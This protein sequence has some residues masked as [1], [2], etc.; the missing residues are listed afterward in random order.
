MPKAFW[1]CSS[2]SIN[3]GLILLSGGRSRPI[4]LPRTTSAPSPHS[5]P[6]PLLL[7]LSFSFRLSTACLDAAL[8]VIHQ[9]GFKKGTVVGGV[10]P[11]YSHD[12]G[13]ARVGRYL[14]ICS[15][16]SIGSEE[17]WKTGVWGRRLLSWRGCVFALGIALHAQLFPGMHAQN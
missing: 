13:L 14:L 12:R 5:S 7:R 4:L 17:P 6:S 9:A 16:A 10:C 3:M 2:Q 1:W 11:Y 15:F 8:L